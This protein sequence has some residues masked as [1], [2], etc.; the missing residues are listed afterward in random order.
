[1]MCLLTTTMTC[2]A[3]KIELVRWFKRPKLNEPKKKPDARH[4]KRTK[5]SK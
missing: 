5:I 3:T 1:M 2:G 4:K